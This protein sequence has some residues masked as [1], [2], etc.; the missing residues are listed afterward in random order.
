MQS[1]LNSVF[2]LEERTPVEE[3]TGETPDISE[4]LDFKFFDRV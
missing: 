1:T 4:Y 3:V 2:D